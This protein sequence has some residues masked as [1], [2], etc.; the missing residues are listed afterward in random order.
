[1]FNTARFGH[2]PWVIPTPFEEFHPDCVE[3][4]CESGRKSVMI[5]G[6]F[7]G[8]LKS[9]LYFVPAGTKIDSSVY[10]T[11][12]LDPLLIPLVTKL[13]RSMCGH[14]WLRMAHQAI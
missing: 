8:T 3:E 11:E 4:R 7:C 12:I 6:A 14:R 9:N 5:W 2:C 10:T 1:M 13:A